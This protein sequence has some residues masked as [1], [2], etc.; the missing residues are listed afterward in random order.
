MALTELAIKHLKPK[1]KLYRVADGGVGGHFIL[2]PR[3][4]DMGFP[5]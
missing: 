3:L 5:R 1:D 2:L 4:S